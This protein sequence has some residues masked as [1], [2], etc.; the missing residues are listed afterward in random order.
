MYAIRS[1]YEPEHN[2]V[3][4]EDGTH[5]EYRQLVVAPGLKLDWDAVEGL[6]ETLGKNGVTSNYRF[7][8]APYT[9]EMVKKLRTSYNFV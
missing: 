7:D 1:Y 3:I 8:Y 9:W 6:R 4:L 2:Q 5:L